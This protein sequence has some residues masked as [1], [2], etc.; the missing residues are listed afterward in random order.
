MTLCDH[1]DRAATVNIPDPAIRYGE[2]YA[3]LLPHELA[4]ALALAEPLQ[5]LLLR[6]FA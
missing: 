6:E 4:Q 1:R 3:D 2:L 5:R